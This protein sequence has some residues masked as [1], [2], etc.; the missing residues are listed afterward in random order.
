[1]N[2]TRRIVDGGNHN[3]ATS[4]LVDAQRTA[5][6]PTFASDMSELVTGDPSPDDTPY[7]SAINDALARCN[8]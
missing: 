3:G 7:I 5:A 2:A 6:N 4:L 8:S 1:M